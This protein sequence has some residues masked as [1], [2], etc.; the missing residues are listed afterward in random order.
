MI[1]E[2]ELPHR[3]KKV[4]I[5]PRREACERLKVDTRTKEQKYQDKLERNRKYYNEGRPK[6]V[7]PVRKVTS[8]ET[9]I[10]YTQHI[11][12]VP[13]K[14]I[15]SA[16]N[17]CKGTVWMHIRDYKRKLEKAEKDNATYHRMMR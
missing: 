9:L 1:I 16:L 15:A 2:A 3:I 11:N 10:M 4:I 12:G 14:D 8:E 6:H 5:P 17:Y 13:V 7:A